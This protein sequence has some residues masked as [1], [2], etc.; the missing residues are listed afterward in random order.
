MTTREKR[1][2]SKIV[3]EH[4]GAVGVSAWPIVDVDG[5]QEPT[6]EGEGY[7]HTTISGKTRVYHPNAYGWPTLYHPSTK[8]IVVGRGWLIEQGL[9]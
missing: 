4:A 2:L 1:R 8:R 7:Y 6:V 3:R 5:F 9:V